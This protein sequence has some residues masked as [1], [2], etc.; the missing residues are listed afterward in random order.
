MRTIIA[1]GF[2][3]SW[4]LQTWWGWTLGGLYMALSLI[5]DLWI[6]SDKLQEYNAKR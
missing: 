1:L 3:I 6:S 2:V 4:D 5:I